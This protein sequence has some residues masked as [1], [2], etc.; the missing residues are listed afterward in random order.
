MPALGGAPWWCGG[1]ETACRTQRRPGGVGGRATHRF[2]AAWAAQCKAVPAVRATHAHEMQCRRSQ[3][4]QMG[5]A[6]PGRA[7]PQCC[8]APRRCR[9]PERRLARRQLEHNARAVPSL[10]PC[11]MLNCSCRLPAALLGTGSTVV[12]AKPCCCAQPTRQL[13][14]RLQGCQAT[15]GWRSPFHSMAAQGSITARQRGG[16]P[17]QMAQQVGARIRGT[18]YPPAQR[19]CCPGLQCCGRGSAPRRGSPGTGC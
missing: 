5:H 4:M 10:G 17:T 16:L 19:C 2:R 7:Q 18:K 15:N 13:C 14:A 12:P 9:C 6:P 8:R 3:C 11:C 1:P